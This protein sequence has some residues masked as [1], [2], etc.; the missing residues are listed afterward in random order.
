VLVL[1]AD[2]VRIL[3]FEVIRLIDPMALV[4]KDG[5]RMWISSNVENKLRIYVFQDRMQNCVSLS[6]GVDLET[7]L[8]E[9]KCTEH[10]R[11]YVR[12]R[13]EELRRMV[14]SDDS[15]TAEQVSRMIHRLPEEMPRPASS[16]TLLARVLGLFRRSRK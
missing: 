12:S 13:V 3:V 5:E 10:E 15:I 6:R 9:A 14:N 4:K 16:P 8:D 11:R 2:G 7:A 1:L